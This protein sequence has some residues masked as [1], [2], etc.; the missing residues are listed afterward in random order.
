MIQL[1]ERVAFNDF[2]LVAQHHPERSL[3]KLQ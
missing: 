1:V 2:D 3:P